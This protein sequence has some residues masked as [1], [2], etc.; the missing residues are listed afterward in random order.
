MRVRLMTWN[1]HRAIGV[2]R[3]FRPERVAAVI[4]HHQ[5]DVLLLQE[6]DRFVPRSGRL[7]LAE[8][9][10]EACGYPYHS[11]AQAHVLAEG[12][13][14]NATLSRFPI[15]RRRHFDLTLNG[16]K[17]R[18][19]LYTVLDPPG[20]VRDLYLFNMHLGLGSAERAEQ[21]RRFLSFD[22]IRHLPA[23]A[24]IIVAGDTNDWRN[25]LY[26]YGGLAKAGF[27]TWGGHGRRQ[28]HLT[29]PSLAPITALDK[30]FWRGPLGEP[31]VHISRLRATRVASDHLPLLAEFDL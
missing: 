12:S 27:R 21:M 13:Y 2:D 30:F 10:A 18:G 31:H 8:F 28:S 25:R 23:S 1:I 5:P 14:G 6:V 16:R 9:L 20:P 29:F 4:Q 17:Q 3:R 22:V 24:R 15:R 26:H 7:H 19:C 11:W